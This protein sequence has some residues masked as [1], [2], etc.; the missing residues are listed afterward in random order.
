MGANL[1]HKTIAVFILVSHAS[2]RYTLAVTSPSSRLAWID[3]M[4]GLACVL[5]FQ[6]HC[7][8]A[9]LGGDARNTS[10]LK[11]SQ[12]LG[13]L[14]APLFLFLA[15]VSF[16]LITDKLIRKSLSPAEI[17]RTMARRG[18]E[19]LAFGLLFRLQEFLIAWGWAPWSDL[20]RVDILN[21]IGLSMI[22]MAL[23]CGIILT[24]CQRTGGSRQG[25]LP[26]ASYR[27]MPSGIPQVANN[28]PGFSR[29]GY[30]L[31]GAAIAAAALL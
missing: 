27:G 3:W 1:G 15:G 5:M 24:V 12:L 28:G 20:L 23:T 22:L 10:F 19:I 26:S 25:M 16:A 2:A 31:I 13:T 21:I 8:D 11:A 14:P 7:Y 6:T 4:R 17:T 29:C 30:L 9:W 18:A